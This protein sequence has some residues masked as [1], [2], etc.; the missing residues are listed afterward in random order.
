MGKKKEPDLSKMSQLLLSGATMLGESCPDCA[1]PLFKKN[2][3][4]F[5]PNCERKA[6]YIKNKDEIKKIEQTISLGDA[7]N[8]LRDVLIGKI[9]LLTNQLAS[10]DTPNEITNTLEIIEKILNIIQKIS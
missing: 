5:C 2:E 8:Q 10:E 7:T 1:V 6:V 9:T 4:I 3:N